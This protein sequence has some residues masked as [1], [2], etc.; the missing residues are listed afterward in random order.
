MRTHSH[1]GLRALLVG[2]ALAALAAASTAAQFPQPVVPQGNPIT[3]EKTLLG[4]ALFWEEQLSS[5]RLTACGSCHIPA[6]GGSDPRSALPNA[7][8]HPG[9]D[10]LFGTADDAVGSPGVPLSRADAKYEDEPSFG[11]DVQVTR[12]KAPTMINAAFAPELFW[13]GRATSEFYDPLTNQ[14]LLPFNGAL[15][16]QA[17]GPPLSTAEM[18]HLGRDL[19]DVAA[20]IAASKPLA[21]AE[22]VPA[23]LEQWIGA[24]TYPELFAE[25]F[26]TPEVTP[27]RIAFALATYQRTLVSDQ[28]PFDAWVQ[29]V[30]N[31]LTPEELAGKAIFDDPN[32]GCLSCH[33]GPTFTDD[34]YHYIGVRPPN[35][36]LG[37][38]EV[39]GLLG[40]RGQFRT[41]GL[42]NVG[43]RGP[44]FHDGSLATLEEVVAFYDRGG[45]FSAPNKDPR[46]VP[47]GLTPIQ[48]TQLVA[49]LRDAL[50]D[51]RVAAEQFPF[52]RPVL[53]TESARVPTTYG[54]GTP[55]SG[56][57]VPSMVALEPPR[58]GNPD[59]TLAVQHARGGASALLVVGTTPD[60]TGTFRRGA[61]LHVSLTSSHRITAHVI[62]GVGAG[63]GFGSS[64]RRLPTSPLL[65]GT[66]FY[67]QWL[68]PDAGAPAGLAASEAVRFEL[69]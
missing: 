1:Y 20:R 68:V 14:L 24:R 52:D 32:N 2:G 16:S 6:A 41:P 18:G 30:P 28:T 37:R 46:I 31:A 21:L 47:L 33:Q 60:I 38:E 10:L 56:G 13:D 58:L 42:R 57:H 34:L 36:D 54:A 65:A 59:F 55:G 19:L 53:Y 7:L 39:T 45:D 67:A 17:L 62:E 25:A 69:F 3:P 48:Q 49:F 5:T 40:N 61:W 26:G 22:S 29:G 23:P 50:T 27:T 64:V 35:E 11:L 51:P 9:L 8:V 15:E 66:A 44:F 43:L 12:R 63:E 4:K